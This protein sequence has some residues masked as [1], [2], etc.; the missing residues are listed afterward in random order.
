MAKWKTH[1]H[2]AQKRVIFHQEPETMNVLHDICC[3]RTYQTL[4]IC[5]R[6]FSAKNWT[7][8]RWL[9]TVYQYLM[10]RDM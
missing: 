9:Q 8:K 4:D 1:T 7:R 2:V 6:S 5:I 10:H 3:K